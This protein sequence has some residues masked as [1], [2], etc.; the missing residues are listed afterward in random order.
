MRSFDNPIDNIMLKVW[1]D[2]GTKATWLGLGENH[3]VRFRVCYGPFN[4]N[5]IINVME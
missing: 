1:L 3:L 2:V 4:T 5:H